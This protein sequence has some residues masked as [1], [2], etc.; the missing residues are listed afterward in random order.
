MTCE[1]MQNKKLQMLYNI[2]SW[3]KMK[4]FFTTV[5]ND[6]AKYLCFEKVNE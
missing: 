3:L 1:R 6:L 5:E 2:L 4:E